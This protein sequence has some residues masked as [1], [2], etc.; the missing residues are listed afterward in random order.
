LK[1]PFDKMGSKTENK[2]VVLF[3]RTAKEKVLQKISIVFHQNS[4]EAIKNTDCCYVIVIN[5]LTI[6]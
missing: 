1:L 2:K 4:I 5:A 3:F 6:D